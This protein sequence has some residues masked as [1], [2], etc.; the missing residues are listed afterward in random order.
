MF[1]GMISGC[2]VSRRLLP[3]E[4]KFS[5]T[6]LEALALLETVEHFKMY[7]AGHDFVAYT[8]HQALLGVLEGVPSSTKL[9][10]WKLKLAEYAMDVRYIKGINNP[11]ADA[12][13]RQGWP[14][15]QDDASSV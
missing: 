11:I 15:T 8:D 3:R 1:A 14:V 4:T 10:R 2:L 9:T 12:M 13:S 7:L 6:E 5:A